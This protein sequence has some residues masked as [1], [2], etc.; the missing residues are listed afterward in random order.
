MLR[1]ILTV[2]VSILFITN[3]AASQEKTSEPE[4][5]ES[6][7]EQR[8]SYGFFGRLNYNMHTASFAGEEWNVPNCC[9]E[10][11]SGIGF[12]F[13][14]GAFYSL[15]IMKNWD[16]NLRLSYNNLSAL[17]SR[18]EPI[19]VSNPNGTSTDG[20]F[21]HQI[22]ASLSSI[23]LSPL[24]TY[25][26]TKQ[27]SLHLGF[28]AGAFM[29]SQ[30]SQKEEI[31]EPSNGYFPDTGDRTRHESDGDIPNASALDVAALVGL[32]YSLPLN[33]SFEWFLEPEVFYSFGVMPVSSDVSWTANGLSGGIAIK[34]APR[35]VIE[36]IIPPKEAPAPPLPAPPPPPEFKA[37]ITAVSVDE[38]GNESD[39]S[40]IRVNEY[41][42]RRIHPLLN[43]IFFDNNSAE[44]SPR[45]K[46]MGEEEKENFSPNFLVDLET[47]EVY[48]QV[49]NIV[50][51]RMKRYPNTT[52]KLIGC[53][54]NQG[55]EKGNIELS[56]NR[57]ENVKNFLINEW[58]INGERIEIE[59][60]NLPEIPSNPSTPAGVEENRRVEMKTQ[61]NDIIFAPLTVR[62]TLRETTPPMLRFKPRVEAEV[63]VKN[64]TVRTWQGD[65]ELKVF[66][67]AGSPPQ[68]LEID[69]EN[70]QEYVPILDED[71]KYQLTITDNNNNTWKS[72]VKRLEV[73]PYTIQNKYLAMLNGEKVDARDFDQFSLISF[74]FNKS[75][76]KPEHEPIV[77]LAKRRIKE[78]S[79]V[80]IEGHTD[81]TGEQR[82]NIELSK[83]RANTVAEE[84]GVDKS[85]AVGLGMKNP[86]YTNELPEGRFYNRTVVISVETKIEL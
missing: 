37:F 12:G 14:I 57:A 23:A 77:K 20:L 32:S 74:D 60:K 61:Y 2:V 46:R 5:A 3:L 66:K 75:Y 11:E 9:P 13:G 62:D 78:N 67:G 19:T 86:L 21:E 27:V 65:K 30:Y 50:G 72:E 17:L 48:H 83:E 63:G 45:Y 39:V 15:P 84:L 41:L 71:F 73:Q 36:P 82:R 22:D 80:E 76:L 35:E 56:R 1:S 18:E 55:P 49:L 44:I 53:N 6:P 85:K 70:E 16:L 10:F 51:N 79:K 40:Q 59:A 52:I 42:S 33:K 28:R 34:Y 38:E 68:K 25:R 8:D 4:Y 43:F 29:V 54:A 81:N 31:K 7:Y 24:A 69:L 64:W 58:D 26:T 47:M